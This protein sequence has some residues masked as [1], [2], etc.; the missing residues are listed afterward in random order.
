MSVLQWSDL[1]RNPRRVA[2]IV[3]R[4][5]EARIERRGDEQLVLMEARRYDTAI[6]HLETLTQLV[7]YLVLGSPIETAVKETFPWTEVMPADARQRFFAEFVETFDACRSLDV[8]KPLEQLFIEW[9][10]TA[11]VFADPELDAALRGPSSTEDLEPV[12][13]PDLPEDLGPAA[14]RGGP[15]AEAR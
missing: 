5:G 11:A 13:P 7:R 10:A 6:E 2:E 1:A 4:D 15:N 9:Q 12:Q 3:E 14:P 8:W